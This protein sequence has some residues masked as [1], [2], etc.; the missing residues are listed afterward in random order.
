M[1]PV[2]MPSHFNS[3]RAPPGMPGSP[4][5][6]HRAVEGSGQADP[7]LSLNVE[8]ESKKSGAVAPETVSLSIAHNR[9]YQKVLETPAGGV[10]SGQRCS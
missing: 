2:E 7:C 8:T 6:C 4:G 1:D 9:A 5:G 10:G 3:K